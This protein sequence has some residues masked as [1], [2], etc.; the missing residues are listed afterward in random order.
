MKIAVNDRIFGVVTVM[1]NLSS[2]ENQNREKLRLENQVKR[3]F[4]FK[5]FVVTD[6]LCSKRL[7]QIVFSTHKLNWN[8]VLIDLRYQDF[9]EFVNYTRV[10]KVVKNK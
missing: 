10:G 1:A 6:P 9:Q 8:F 7:N 2:A 5:F 4:H 3:H